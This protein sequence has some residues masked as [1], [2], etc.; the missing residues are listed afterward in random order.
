MNTTLDT[1]TRE[2]LTAWIKGGYVVIDMTEAG[3]ERLTPVQWEVLNRSGYDVRRLKNFLVINEAAAAELRDMTRHGAQHHNSLFEEERIEFG[4]K[5]RN[6]FIEKWAENAREFGVGLLE[7]V[8]KFGYWER[9]G[10]TP[11]P[12]KLV[13]GM[14][15]MGELADEVA[16]LMTLGCLEDIAFALFDRDAEVTL[17]AL[18]A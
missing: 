8:Q 15:G 17:E 4:R 16:E 6:Y 11:T 5:H 12:D 13:L 18:N 14:A 7:D 1:H 2:A 10:I 9:N 3:V